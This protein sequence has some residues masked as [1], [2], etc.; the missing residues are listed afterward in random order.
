MFVSV[1]KEKSS[2]LS[3]LVE[4]GCSISNLVCEFMLFIVCRIRLA[5]DLFV[6]RISMSSTYLLYIP[7]LRLW[8][9][10]CSMSFMYMI[11]SIAEVL[12]P[13]GN[14]DIVCKFGFC[15]VGKCFL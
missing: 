12:L 10:C 5:S 11:A 2:K 8:I 4:S 1:E 7:M 13:I 6:V 9:V 3:V 14:P 15:T